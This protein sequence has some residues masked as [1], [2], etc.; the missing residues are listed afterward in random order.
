MKYL[1]NFAQACIV[2]IPCV[3]LGTLVLLACGGWLADVARTAWADGAGLDAL[4]V[5]AIGVITAVEAMRE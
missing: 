2:L 1:S 5:L 3:I 4:L